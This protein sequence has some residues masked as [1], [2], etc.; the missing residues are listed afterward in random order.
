MS[1]SYVVGP[2]CIGDN[3][4]IGPNAVILPGTSIGSNCTIEPF[5][6]ISNSILMKNVKVASFNNISSSIIGEGVSTGSHFVADAAETRVE[7]DGTMMKACM[8]AAIG[9]NT[10]IAGRVLI[11]PG[12]I[13]G[14]RCRI[15][16]GAI[17]RENL[18]DNTRIL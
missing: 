6:R 1:G 9:D 14:V 4:D 12:R 18:P 8:G 17:V 16:A 10:E 5:T 13:V 7:M 11:S 2:V 15:G 3:C